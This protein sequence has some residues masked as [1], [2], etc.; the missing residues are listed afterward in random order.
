MIVFFSFRRSFTF[1]PSKNIAGSV[2]LQ[3]D[4][5]SDE[6]FDAQSIRTDASFVRR[7]TLLVVSSVVR[8]GLPS[9]RELFHRFAA[10]L[11]RPTQ[12]FSSLDTTH[13]LGLVEPSKARLGNQS[14]QSVCNPRSAES[15][16]I[17]GDTQAAAFIDRQRT[18][19]SV[20]LIT[21]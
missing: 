19:T 4:V 21:A 6:S 18:L 3:T 2:V 12:T 13:F 5:E 15:L 17:T 10:R 9:Q 1:D 11:E 16:L 14:N 7:P 20:P 8:S